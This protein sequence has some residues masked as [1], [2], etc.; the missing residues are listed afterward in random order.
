MAYSQSEANLLEECRQLRTRVEELEGVLRQYAD[1]E[2]WGYYDD[3]GCTKGHGRYEDACF[4][5]PQP[6]RD[7]LPDTPQPTDTEPN[8][9]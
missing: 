8:G 7:A 6:A 2:N 5:G 9:G 4:I 3:S 1:P